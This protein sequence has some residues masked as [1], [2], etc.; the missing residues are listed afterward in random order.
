[1]YDSQFSPRPE[2]KT[3]RVQ[4]N[5]CDGHGKRAKGKKT[6]TMRVQEEENK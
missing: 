4:L 2:L 1:M 5:M 6:A 3:T